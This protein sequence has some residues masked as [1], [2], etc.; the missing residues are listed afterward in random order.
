MSIY[1]IVFLALVAGAILEHIRKKTPKCLFFLMYLVLTAV[2]CLRFGQGKDYFS[3][4]SIFRYL[5]A[6]PIAALDATNHSEPGWKF[7]NA[8]FKMLGVS[9]PIFIS[10]LSLFMMVMFLRFLNRFC[11]QRKF[12]ALVLSYHTLY[13]SYF[14]STIRQGVLI[15]VL[16]GVLLQWM[17][18][19]KLVRF[20]LVTLLL[21]TIHSIALLIALMPILRQ[22]HL[23]IKQLICM[24][25]LG[26]LFGVALSVVNVG[27]ILG[28]FMD[29]KYL[30]ETEI[31]LVAVMERL[32]TF[33]VVT[34]CYYLYREGMEPEAA[35]PL[36]TIYKIYALGV[37]LYGVLMWSALISSR[38][39]YILKVV[40]I[41]MICVCV[42]KCK[43]SATLVLSYCL[44]L[45][46]VLYVKNVGSYLDQADYLDHVNVYNYPYVTIFNRKDI[47]NYRTDIISYP[48]ENDE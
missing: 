31:S 6:D 23:N 29:S 33:A 1:H 2:L 25:A 11:G 8:T 32:V 3:Y 39:V 34:F 24:V 30:M 45:S 26:Y 19:R 28:L 21:T 18:E 7:L 47:L 44:L 14:M 43:K 4:A 40:E 12:L 41:L 22:I 48:F 38:A 16:L 13:M 37:C 42:I 35:D 36:H 15:A 10:I 5:P 20:Y 27:R 9:F 46:G 17:M